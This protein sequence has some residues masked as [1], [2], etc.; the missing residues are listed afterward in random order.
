[1]KPIVLSVVALSLFLLF[2]IPHARAEAPP[3]IVFSAAGDYGF[4][5]ESWPVI[6]DNGGEF[7]LALGDLSYGGNPGGWCSSFKSY[8][9]NVVIVSEIGRAHV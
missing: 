4:D 2:L 7:H 5:A 6:S 9:N 1:M 3:S 8:F